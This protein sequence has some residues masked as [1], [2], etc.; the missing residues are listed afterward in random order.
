MHLETLEYYPDM[1]FG[2]YR[3]DVRAALMPFIAYRHC[4]ALP[5]IPA[6]SQRFLI[7]LGTERLLQAARRHLLVAL[8]CS[9]DAC[10]SIRTISPLGCQ[11]P[12]I[13]VPVITFGPQRPDWNLNFDSSLGKVGCTLH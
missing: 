2:R 12:G 3:G 13:T 9:D 11:L 7:T 8:V 4:L 6:P 1:D 5:S 10:L